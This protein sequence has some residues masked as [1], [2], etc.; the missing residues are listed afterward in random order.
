MTTSL[1]KIR[2]YAGLVFVAYF[3]FA[4]LI[5]YL[6]S[7]SSLYAQEADIYIENPAATNRNKSRPAVYFSHEN[8]MDSYDCLDCHHDYQ[9]GENVLDEDDLE[10]GKSAKCA[11]CHS[12]KASIDLETAYHRECMGC[13]RRFNKQEADTAPIT[14]QDC[15]N[16][17][18]PTP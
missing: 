16:R 11:S 4:T 12:K 2:I 8:H 5:P 13:H 9:N 10:G 6:V 15:H 3:L 7:Y 18:S 14:C 1:R 17:R